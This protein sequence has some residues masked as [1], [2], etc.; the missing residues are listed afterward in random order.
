MVT[1]SEARNM[2]AKYAITRQ[3]DKL[4]VHMHLKTQ[5]E[6]DNI[7]T[8]KPEIMVELIRREQKAE[9]EK[10]AEIEIARAVRA[11]EIKI[12]PSWTS[13]EYLSAW[14]VYGEAGI[15][16][17]EI[18]AAKYIDGWGYAVSPDIID[19]L[20][21]EFT[22]PQAVEIMRPVIEASE[23]AAKA[24]AV[25]R[26]AKIKEAK[27]TGQRV[28]IHSWLEDCND[29]LEECS[30]DVVTE[31]AMPDGTIKIVRQHTW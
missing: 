17:S 1:E 27:K 5:T 9:A 18:G 22:I 7:R 31:Y 3:G 11:G 14:Q 25:E 12:I 26:D 24:R 4:A 10:M 2:I 6:I 21:K 29:P 20:G 8:A 28:E 23:S 15:A 13:G 16:M 19:A 30:S